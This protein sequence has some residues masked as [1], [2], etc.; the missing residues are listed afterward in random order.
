MGIF[1]AINVSHRDESNDTSITAIGWVDL[2]IVRTHRHTDTHA[3]TT[4]NF[5][6]HPFNNL[7]APNSNYESCSG[8]QAPAIGEGI[9]AIRWID[10]EIR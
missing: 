7:A 3:N 4:E 5:L 2:E 6:V 8:G 9:S 10:L 1:V